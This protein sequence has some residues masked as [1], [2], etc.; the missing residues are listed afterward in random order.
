MGVDEARYARRKGALASHE[1]NL[2]R[3]AVD[4]TLA[5]AAPRRRSRVDSRTARTTQPAGTEAHPNWMLMAPL[6][7]PWTLS[8]VCGHSSTIVGARGSS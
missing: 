2:A 3:A 5:G 8:Q 6:A 1:R 4:A 7:E